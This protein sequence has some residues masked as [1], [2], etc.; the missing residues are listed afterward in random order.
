MGNRSGFS[1]IEIMVVIVV[2]GVVATFAMPRT[3]RR[4]PLFQVDTA[5]RSLVRDIELVRM[6]AMAAKRVVRVSFDEERAF[7]T[8]FMDVSPGRQG[9]LVE[10]KEEVHASRIVARGSSGGKP[11]V[12]LG[13]G[14]VFATGEAGSGPGDLTAGDAIAFEN[15]RVEFDAAGMVIPE[16]VGGVVF[17]AHEDDPS[18]VAAVTISG[19]GAVRAWRYRNG[20]WVQ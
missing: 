19:A 4:S 3:G 18:A 12:K 11:G 10:T 2:L 5:A 17:L 8:A 7:Y 16:G 9:D 13:D 1:L 6:R 20:K 14:V 15:D